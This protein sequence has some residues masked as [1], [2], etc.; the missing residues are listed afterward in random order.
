MPFTSPGVKA[1]ETHVAWGLLE[2]ARV[3]AEAQY[4][5]AAIRNID[6][7]LTR[8][9]AN[10]WFADCCVIN[11][12]EPLTHTLGYA[13][14]GLIEGWRYSADQKL[15]RAALLTGTNMLEAIGRDGFLP[16]RL[17][18]QWRGTVR[19][20]CLTQIFFLLGLACEEFLELTLAA[21][22]CYV[23]STWALTNCVQLAVAWAW[24]RRFPELG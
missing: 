17:D 13:L 8:Q 3:G 4:A 6:W 23:T 10:G 22:C 2:A 15:L 14:R 18:Q 16:G 7:A 9:Q 1:Y 11:P 5:A 21:A 24:L 20:A 12:A 19:W